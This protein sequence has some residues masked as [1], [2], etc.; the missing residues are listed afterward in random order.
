MAAS[1]LC[2]SLINA[3]KSNQSNGIFPDEVKI[4]MVFPLD[5]DTSKAN[6]VLNFQL[7]SVLTMSWKIYE[8]VTKNW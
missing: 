2:Q 1:V 8:S 7:V 3:I 5:K 6:D 4:V